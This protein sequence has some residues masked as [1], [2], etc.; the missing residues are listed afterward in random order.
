M[1]EKFRYF[2]LLT[3]KQFYRL[4]PC[5]SEKKNLRKKKI[6]FQGIY[7]GDEPL[8]GN[9]TFPNENRNFRSSKISPFAANL[10]MLMYNCSVGKK[11]NFSLT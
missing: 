7:G 9:V 4:L 6:K 11:K 10:A 8:E 2:V 5:W 3:Q 1:L